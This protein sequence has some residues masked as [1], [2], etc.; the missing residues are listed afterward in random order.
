M[1][2]LFS[3]IISVDYSATF[4]VL[5]IAT[6]ATKIGILL[7]DSTKRAERLMKVRIDVQS[8]PFYNS[9]FRDFPRRI[10]IK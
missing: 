1:R 7:P 9:G 5:Y 6:T 10:R 8:I 3:S 4:S 2:V